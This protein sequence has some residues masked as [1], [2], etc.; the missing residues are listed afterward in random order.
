MK[1]TAHALSC[2]LLTGAM[3]CLAAEAPTPQSFL[4]IGNSFTFRH[5]MRDV[6]AALAKEGNPAQPLTSEM[7][8]YGG[9]DLFRHYEIF[10][11]QDFLR[12]G[13]LTDAELRQSID[14]MRERAQPGKEPD[15]Y[16]EYW[17]NID[18]AALVPFEQYEAKDNGVGGARKRTDNRKSTRWAEEQ[19]LITKSAIKHH[20]E[21]IKDRSRFPA[22]WNYVVLQSWQ[23]VS[24]NP[25]TGYQKYATKF[26]ELAKQ[27]NTKPILYITAPN[28]QNAN[29]VKE[30][31]APEATLKELHIVADLAKRTGAIVVPVPLAVYRLQK[32]GA[33]I[34]LRYENDMHPNQA[35]AYLTAC[36][37]YAAVFNKSPE[38]LMLNEVTETKIVDPDKPDQD[39]DG[40]PL[41]RTFTDAERMLLQRTAWETIEAFRKGDY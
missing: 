17:K 11:S 8:V 25:E 13:S 6:F 19:K 9:R 29:L 21:W 38:G 35:C 33:P 18:S 2:L 41:K 40:H 20:Q 1:A 15:F 37:F 39:P 23:D 5:D 10:K 26:I 4:F 34:T 16:A 14:K 3:T 24:A 31:L 27:Q 7:V 28:N 36:L 32:A 22:T 12:L 30:P